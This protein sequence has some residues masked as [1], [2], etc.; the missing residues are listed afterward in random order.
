MKSYLF[1][2]LILLN[3][4][5]PVVKEPVKVTVKPVEN[6]IEQKVKLKNVVV[7]YSG[8]VKSHHKV[9]DHLINLL[10][11]RAI[12]VVLSGQ[13]ARDA[14]LIKDIRSSNTTQIAA[15]GSNAVNAVKA[16][17]NK[18]IIFSQIVIS[19]DLVSKNVKGVSALPSPEKLFK[20]WKALSPALSKVAIIAGDNLDVYLS[21]AKKAAKKY[22]IELIV[23]QFKT[24][25]EFVYRSK[26][27]KPDIEGQWIIPDNRV[28]SGHAL[29]DVMAYASRRGR[30]IVV[31][32]PN[33]LAFGGFL[34][35]GS[36]PKAVAKGVFKR[37]SASIGKTSIPGDSVLPIMSHT[38]IINKRIA[39]QLNL[40]IP[41]EYR[42]YLNEQEG[43]TE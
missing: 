5:A 24:D 27:L 32:S 11:E 19:E 33:L 40:K 7:I 29:K 8:T 3:A 9:A 15:I 25:K 17:P 4:C 2:I 6:K 34:Y 21:G 35:V 36:N 23:K 41:Q 14:V 16:I 37:L 43:K 1:I 20:D 42:K 39:Q 30:Q 38:M 28:L 13:S 10:G 31:F 12:S 26:A 18:Q 22:N